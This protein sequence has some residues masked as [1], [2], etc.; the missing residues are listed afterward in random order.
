MSPESP[1]AIGLPM[2]MAMGLVFGMGPCLLSCLPYLGP[3]FLGSDEGVARSW[4]IMLP[5]SLGRL[6]S[7]GGLG[8]ASG[9]VGHL[10]EDMIGIA[11][12]RFLVGS[13][14]LLMGVALLA[15]ERKGHRL[16]S[17]AAE[18]TRPAGL[19]L[20]GLGLGMTPC[21]P[22]GAVLVSAAA[23][24]DPVWGGVLGLC[25]GLGA[26]TVPA[27]AY[28][29]GGAFIGAQLRN[30]LGRWRTGIERTSAAL[31]IGSGLLGI[32]RGLGL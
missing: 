27:I 3:V 18:T 21:A 31:L 7:Y 8:I 32:W 19:V 24:S 6:G 30:A 20:M 5:L 10:A 13:A 2:A 28:G 17:L 4:R 12:I 1:L 26:I 15:G 16:C 14:A 29:I 22:L 11:A 23:S 9:L 25:F